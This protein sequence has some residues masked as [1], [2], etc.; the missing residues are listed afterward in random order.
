MPLSPET[1]ALYFDRLSAPF[2]LIEGDGTI[3]A[4]NRAFARALQRPAPEIM[5]TSLEVLVSGSFAKTQA[6]LL[7]CSRT[8]APLPGSL[9]FPAADGSELAY[10]CEGVLLMPRTDAHPARLLLRLL[11]FSD[12]IQRFSLLTQQVNLLRQE[13]DEHKRTEQISRVRQAEI[14]ELNARL[15]RAMRETHHRVKNNLQIIAAMIEMQMLEHQDAQFIPIGDYRALKSH[16]HTLSIIHDLLTHNLREDEQSQ[17]LSAKDLLDQ[18]LPRL[19]QTA[20]HRAVHCTAQDALLTARMSTALSL[21][22]NELVTNALKYGQNEICIGFRVADDQ[23]TLE[24]T[25]DGAG[26]PDDFD[27]R[28]RANMG[29]ELVESL[30]QSDLRGRSHYGRRAEGGG[31][32]TVTFPLPER[33]ED[34]APQA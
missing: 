25:D 31:K 29:L 1:F 22:L 28:A 12:A 34:H 8:S 13:I 15:S 21:V 23:A 5:G 20:G 27:A 18:L 24:V 17:R 33:V 2:L 19:Q 4:V 10:R 14:E 6:Y 9:T 32:V 3:V 16:I 7:A 26:F 11:P 30:V